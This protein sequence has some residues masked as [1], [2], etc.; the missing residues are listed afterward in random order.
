MSG[1]PEE[2]HISISDEEPE[3][4]ERVV[5]RRPATKKRPMTHAIAVHDAKRLALAELPATRGGQKK[6]L[7]K[8]MSACMSGN[9]TGQNEA[10][11]KLFLVLATKAAYIQH[12]DAEGNKKHVVTCTAPQA[13]KMHQ[14]HHDVVQRVFA[15][16]VSQNLD[17]PNAVAFRDALLAGEL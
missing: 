16:C 6:V 7:K 13:A 3:E 14:N 9:R 17:K 1:E 8:P 4:K 2:D 10:L 11:G 5:R 12:L 15:A